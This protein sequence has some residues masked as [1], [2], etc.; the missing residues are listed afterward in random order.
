MTQE[1]GAKEYDLR[2][3]QSIHVPSVRGERLVVGLAIAG[4]WIAVLGTGFVGVACA[5][6]RDTLML[7]RDW[8]AGTGHLIGWL[9]T[10]SVEMGFLM[11]GR[12]PKPAFGPDEVVNIVWTKRATDNPGTSGDVHISPAMREFDGKQWLPVTRDANVVRIKHC[13]FLIDQIVFEASPDSHERHVRF[14]QCTTG[15]HTANS[16]ASGRSDFCGPRTP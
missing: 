14:K 15:E 1:H 9:P 12:E 7:V 4:V 10:H 2:T 11:V 16:F 8:N 3:H 5:Q 13:L 6:E